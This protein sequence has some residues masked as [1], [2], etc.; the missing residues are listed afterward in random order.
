M[1]MKFD[2]KNNF[3]LI[4]VLFLTSFS[5]YAQKTVKQKINF[6]FYL[7]NQNGDHVD[8]YVRRIHEQVS[9]F[10]QQYAQLDI[11]WL[12]II[13]QNSSVLKKDQNLVI[14]EHKLG[15]E[16]KIAALPGADFSS[17]ETLKKFIETALN[18]KSDFNVLVLVNHGLGDEGIMTTA[19]Q[20]DQAIE[21]KA[22]SNI[23]MAKSIVAAES[24]S[25]KKIDLIVLDACLMGSIEVIADFSV[26]GLN[27][28]LVLSENT[29]IPTSGGTDYHQFFLL[30]SKQ[31]TKK[32]V[33]AIEMGKLFVKANIKNPSANYALID[34]NTFNKNQILS[35]FNNLSE[36]INV[37]LKKDQAK[38]FNLINS[39]APSIAIQGGVY[40]L[41]A[42][43][44]ILEKK[45]NQSDFKKKIAA[46]RTSL[47]QTILISETD[48]LQTYESG[49]S[50][51]LFVG[52]MNEKQRDAKLKRYNDLYFSKQTK[53]IETVTSLTSY[54]SVLTFE[55]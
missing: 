13:N 32:P 42:V 55:N 15:I 29:T 48:N 12:T 52:G 38:I 18:I 7:D 28:P 25:Q 8:D 9:N 34:L 6:M 54:L 40:D 20:T 17:P 11:N 3:L 21:V 1:F 43:L 2:L 16:T 36:N 4:L 39:A 50:I 5:V 37:L 19:L 27:T 33:T 23:D 10:S 31:I 46:L 24:V 22:M 26:V 14:S 53:W 51:R 30:L 44:S 45:A 41:G 49:I 47:K 35:Q